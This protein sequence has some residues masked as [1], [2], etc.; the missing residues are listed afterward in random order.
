MRYPK[1]FLPVLLISLMIFSIPLASSADEKSPAL[2]IIPEQ[3]AMVKG[4][5]KKFKV[6]DSSSG[7]KVKKYKLSS[8]SSKI[9]KVSGGKLIAQKP[10]TVTITAKSGNSKGK[11]K[12][13]VFSGNGDMVALKTVKGKKALWHIKNGK[14]VK[15]TGIATD[16]IYNYYC[17]KGQVDKKFSGLVKAKIDGTKA[18]W[19]VK[20][21]VV[22]TAFLGV[23]KDKD[24]FVYIRNGKLV[25]GY[26]GIASDKNKTYRFE[27]GK[28]VKSASGKVSAFF[29][30][31][32]KIEKNETKTIGRKGVTLTLNS[33]ADITGYIEFTLTIDG[34]EIKGEA[35]SSTWEK[36]NYKSYYTGLDTFNPIYPRFIRREGDS[37]VFTVSSGV[38]VKKPLTISGSAKDSYTTSE[39]SYV[40]SDNFVV[41]IPKG[42]TFPGNLLDFYEK[43][44]KDVEAE[45][46]FKKKRS[47]YD[48]K[49]RH[50]IS[51]LF[52]LY[53][54]D[55]LLGVNAD[56]KKIP[57]YIR[58]TG[59]T[60]LAGSASAFIDA[61]YSSIEI[62]SNYIDINQ[63]Y[64]P[65]V[66]LHEYTHYQHLINSPQPGKVLTEGYADYIA[67]RIEKKYPD[68]YEK[69][70]GNG[71][72]VEFYKD[73][74]TCSDPEKLFK[75]VCDKN[76][77]FYNSRDYAYYYG[78][79]IFEYIEDKYGYDR[80][81][82]LMLEYEANAV[83]NK[84]FGFT[85]SDIPTDTV[86]KILKKNTSDNILN[87]VQAFY[88]EKN[89]WAG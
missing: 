52:R 40:E 89:A 54:N 69:E 53:G 82:Q 78:R 36:D 29:D 83:Y 58:E 71:V 12:I 66:F 27:K 60:E 70:T 19:Y 28:A 62:A 17:R 44:A 42:V 24:E 81:G 80:I 4:S 30:E 26:T 22:Q 88:I 43:A 37:F 73:F 3:G 38:D 50:Q 72:G 63:E 67:Y 87:E 41:F 76:D 79:W 5:E 39:L 74:K 21:G 77:P 16:G 57:I 8:S 31:E 51:E 84:E 35:M 25:P 68:K 33:V 48:A 49:Y 59:T 10:G 47:T 11:I 9:V 65:F 32:F 1:S 14:T 34:K 64:N 85:E 23:V 86:L 46:P 6:V 56:C 20:N 7:K 13:K 75:D 55:D 15:K 18:T 45:V 61:S 2:E